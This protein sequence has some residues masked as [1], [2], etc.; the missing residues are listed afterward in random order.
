M[1]AG[2][3]NDACKASLRGALPNSQWRFLFTDVR[4][5]MHFF[6]ADDFY[7]ISRCAQN[8]EN[9]YVLIWF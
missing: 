1:T 4:S 8:V 5:G 3:L 6:L 9:A 7:T 2:N